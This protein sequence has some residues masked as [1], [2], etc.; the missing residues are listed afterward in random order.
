MLLSP[1][2]NSLPIFNQNSGCSAD[3]TYTP[4]MFCAFK[5]GLN[6]HFFKCTFS[7]ECSNWT[8]ATYC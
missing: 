4:G 8:L 6:G 3:A 5:K 2:N 1:K 7:V